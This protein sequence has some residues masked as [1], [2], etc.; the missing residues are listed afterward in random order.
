M[1]Q[2]TRIIKTSIQISTKR[3]RVKYSKAKLVILS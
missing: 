1:A 3:E 2:E